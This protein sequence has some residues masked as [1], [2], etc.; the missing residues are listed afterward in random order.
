ML[1]LPTIPA[2]LLRVLGIV[3]PCFTAP[4]FL[5]FC[6]LVVGMATATGRRTVT[7]MLTAANL[8]GCWSHDRVHQFFSRAVWDPHR[9]GMTLAKAVVAHLV[10]EDARIVVS[11]DDT[12]FRRRGKTRVPQMFGV[13]GDVPW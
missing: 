4:S 6:H 7:G 2:S 13:L 1:P 3:R 10:P 12:L 11:V 8:A 9:L 5:V